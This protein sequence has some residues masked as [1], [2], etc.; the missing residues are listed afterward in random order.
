MKKML[1]IFALFSFIFMFGCGEDGQPGSAYISFTWDWYVDSYDD[2]NLDTPSWITEYTDY[3]TNDGTFSY[4]Y[5]CSDGVGNF[6][7]WYGTYTIYKNAG[8]EASWFSDG[9][10]GADN[11]FRFGLYG[12]GPDFYL[13]K[14]DVNKTKLKSL[15]ESQLDISKY[16]A[17]PVG[18]EI[19]EIVYS[20]N[21]RYKMEITRQMVKLELK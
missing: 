4:R 21:N 14:S 19:K 20:K 12:Y 1:L 10:D 6:W 8:E 3:N 2:N 7:Y 5:D 13:L 18:E 17:I 9:D 16:N 15:T 11:Y